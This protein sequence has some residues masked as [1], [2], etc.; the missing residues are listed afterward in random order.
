[1]MKH[2][3]YEVIEAIAATTEPSYYLELGVQA[4]ITFKRV[5]PHCMF[6]QGV[7][8]N[9]VPVHT[10]KGKSEMYIGSTD[11]FFESHP[12]IE[13]DLIFIDA[14]HSKRQVLI[15]LNNSLKV[16]VPN[17]II[18][19]HDMDPWSLI[20]E[21]AKYCGDCYKLVDELERRDDINITTLPVGPAGLTFVTRKGETRSQLRHA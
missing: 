11:L 7:D 16:L 6:S 15:D 9:R 12:G 17:G 18:I 14:D 21:Q 2:E 20:M 19:L 10:I 5:R 4:G 1:M 8:I 3:Y 13:P